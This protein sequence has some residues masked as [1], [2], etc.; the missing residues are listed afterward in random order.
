MHENAEEG[1]H[2]LSWVPWK[3]TGI[4]SLSVLFEAKKSM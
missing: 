4:A 2:C 1:Q 3:E